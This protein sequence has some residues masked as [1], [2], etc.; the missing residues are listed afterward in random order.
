MGK[1]KQRAFTCILGNGGGG[2]WRESA[3]IKH[4]SDWTLKDFLSLF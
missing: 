2:S 4:E 3:L 1:I